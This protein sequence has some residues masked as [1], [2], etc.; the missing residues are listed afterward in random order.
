VQA[1]DAAGNTRV[2]RLTL[3]SGRIARA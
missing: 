2:L 1:T 3:R